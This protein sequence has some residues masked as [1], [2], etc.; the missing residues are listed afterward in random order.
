MGSGL[1]E[2]VTNDPNYNQAA[3]T[4]ACMAEAI[5]FAKLKPVDF[6]SLAFYL[7]APE[8]NKKINNVYLKKKN[9][10]DRVKNRCTANNTWFLNDFLPVLNRITIER[11]SFEYL[12]DVISSR[13]N[14]YGADIK[15]FYDEC[16]N[17]NGF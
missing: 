8:D 12:I 7:I 6:D 9:I 4:V 5:K 10:E 15:S 1:S 14:D 13:D 3:R 11:I 16:L 2:G 17:N